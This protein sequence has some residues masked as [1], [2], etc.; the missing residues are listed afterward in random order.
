MKV[1]FGD[2]FEIETNA[3][4]VYA[5]YTHSEDDYVDLIRVFDEVHL[6][7]PKDLSQIVLGQ[8]RFSTFFPLSAVLRQRLIMKVSNETVAPKNQEFPWFRYGI[9]H[10]ASRKVEKWFLWR[11]G[12]EYVPIEEFTN[13]HR[14]L[15]IVGCWNYDMLVQRLEE[16]WRPEFYY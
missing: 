9:P 15:S 4:L 8:V 6:K 7:R 5:Q 10:P 2:L 16:G 13:E 12:D 11:G 1:K 14:G 3:G